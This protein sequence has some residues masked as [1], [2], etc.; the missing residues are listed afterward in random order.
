MTERRSRALN[1]GPQPY[2]KHR[3]SPAPTGRQSLAK[4]EAECE[5]LLGALLT[6]YDKNKRDLPWRRTRDPYAIWVSEAMLQQTQVVTVLP[7]YDRWMSRFPTIGSLANATEQEAL[8]LWQ[9]LGYYRRCRLLLEGARYVAAQGMPSSSESWE[10]VPGVG[11]YTACAISSIALGEQVPVV[12]GNVE[13]VYARLAACYHPKPKLN[14]KAWDWAASLVPAERPGDFNQ[15]LMEL[16]ATVC[17]PANPDCLACPVQSMCQAHAQGRVAELPVRSPKTK[18]VSLQFHVWIPIFE[19]L[20]GLRQIPEGEWW[21]NMWEFPRASS[22]CDLGEIVGEGEVLPCGGLRHSVTHHRITLI[23]S[24][25]ECAG[26][27]EA[28]K[29]VSGEE[30]MQMPLPSPQRKALALMRKAAGSLFAGG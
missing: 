8:S 3:S 11:R 1:M 30:L 4:G 12:D 15:A 16:G 25:I 20:Y 19:G 22:E 10:K 29:W 21:E 5:R 14:K 18:T 13:R 2:L 17:R 28:L 9:G 7:Y 24:Q 26:K 23:V 27:S 6:W